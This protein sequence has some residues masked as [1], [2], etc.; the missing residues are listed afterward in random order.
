MASLSFESMKPFVAITAEALQKVDVV[1]VIAEP[2]VIRVMGYESVSSAALLTATPGVMLHLQSY[3]V[4][5]ASAEVILVRHAADNRRNLVLVGAS[6]FRDH[7][8]K[9]KSFLH[10]PGSKV[11]LNEKVCQFFRCFFH[12]NDRLVI[13][14]ILTVRP[15]PLCPHDDDGG[16]CNANAKLRVDAEDGGSCRRGRPRRERDHFFCKYNDFILFVLFVLC[17]CF[18]TFVCKHN[19]ALIWQRTVIHH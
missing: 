6:G 5:V 14:P 19:R 13:G 9:P 1:H 17:F 10:V 7:A 4:P 18:R 8:I 3:Q 2:A 11:L 15:C 16:D 12:H